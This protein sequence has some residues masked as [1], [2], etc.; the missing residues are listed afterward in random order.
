MIEKAETFCDSTQPAGEE[1]AEF[2]IGTTNWTL[3]VGSQQVE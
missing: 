1:M 2:F 3:P